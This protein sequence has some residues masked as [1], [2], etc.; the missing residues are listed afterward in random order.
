MDRSAVTVWSD[1]AWAARRISGVRMK[2][3]NG[4]GCKWDGMSQ[5]SVGAA[6]N[7]AEK[8]PQCRER[9][10]CY[11]AVESKAASDNE[12][13]EKRQSGKTG[14][15][16]CQMHGAFVNVFRV[17][18]ADTCCLLLVAGFLYETSSPY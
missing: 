14:Y 2:L 6:E 10:H 13:N 17:P 3:A 11:Q 8:L 18:A 1:P 7:N 4:T 15:P 5:R 16:A 12:K 9:Y